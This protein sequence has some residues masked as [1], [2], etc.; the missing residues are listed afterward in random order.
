MWIGSGSRHYAFTVK[1]E[2]EGD[3]ELAKH[4]DAAVVTINLCLSPGNWEGSNL[5]FFASGGSGMYQL[6]KG[7]ESAGDGDVIFHSG[8]AV[9]HRGQHQHQ[10]QQLLS[11][12]RVNL[13]VWLH[14]K[15]G[16]VRIAPYAP[17]EQMTAAQRWRTHRLD[18]WRPHVS[19]PAESTGWRQKRKPLTVEVTKNGLKH[20]ETAGWL[21]IK[22]FWNMLT[23]WKNFETCVPC[24]NSWLQSFFSDLFGSAQDTGWWVLW[25]ESPWATAAMAAMQI[26]RCGDSADWTALVNV[27]LIGWILRCLNEI[28]WM[29]WVK[30][31]LEIEIWDLSFNPWWEVRRGLRL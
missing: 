17:E 26:P 13:V 25:A 14:S 11:G 15:D 6:P 12:Q 5:R 10:A 20:F 8:M 19:V 4:G 3:T 28:Y 2:A 18:L 24:W 31:L 1:Y 16:V 30:L 21:Q 9:I 29:I 27:G 23:I 22:W 7:N